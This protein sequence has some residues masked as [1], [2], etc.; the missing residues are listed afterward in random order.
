MN[1]MLFVAGLLAGA[2]CTRTN[3]ALLDQSLRPPPTCEEGILMYTSPDRAPSG[4]VEL[5][6]LNSAGSTAFTSEAGMMKSQRQK[7]ADIGATGIILGGIDEPG[8][9]AKVAGA[10]LG[11]GTER[12]GKA[13]AIFAVTDTSKVYGVCRQHR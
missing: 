2:A 7:A 8:A 3:V 6:L 5:A 9:G 12:K 1:K 4:Y 13:V 11:T 10:F